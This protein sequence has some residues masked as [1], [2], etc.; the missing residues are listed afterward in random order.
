PG[1]GDG[2]EDAAFGLDQRRR[3]ILDRYAIALAPLVDAFGRGGP[4]ARRHAGDAADESFDHVAPV[5]VHVE[6]DAAATPAIIPARPLAALLAA[7]EH[8]PA[9]FEAEGHDA[10]EFSVAREGGEF[11]QS[12]QMQLVLDHAMF[13]A[14]PLRLP[15]QRVRLR[16]GRRHRLFAI[17]ML[18]GGDGAFENGGALLRCRRI[19]E[20]R[21]SR[22]TESGVES[23]GPNREL[24]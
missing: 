21:V 10:A 3:R 20:N 23:G 18:V 15:Q 1:T 16:G 19:E 4:R 6:E 8:P 5:R 14:A 22:V 17:D 7:V 11:L 12:W 24:V 9:E 2:A 13:A